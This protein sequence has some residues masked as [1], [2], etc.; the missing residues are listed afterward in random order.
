MYD[1]I[2]VNELPGVVTVSLNRPSV[3]NAFNARMIGELTHIFVC[4]AQRE[5]IRAVVLEGNGPSFSAGADVQWMGATVNSAEEENIADAQRMAT[6]FEVIDQLPQP[7]VGKVHGAALGGGM[8]LVA[9]CDLVVAAEG[10]LFGFTEARLGIIPAVISPFV[11][12]K[13]GESWARALFTSAERFETNLAK[14]IGLVHWV[15]DVGDLNQVVAA[16]LETLLS[17][18]PIAVR[19]AK[20]LVRDLRGLTAEEVRDLTPRRIAVLRSSPEGQEGLRAFL[21]KRQAAWRANS[22]RNP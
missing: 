14:D 6:M 21:E 5:D 8:G 12:R 11:I 10:T 16:R 4:L 3:R 18:G 20:A 15:C 22:G 9:V 2:E 17:G 19:A 13:T 7:V 1:T